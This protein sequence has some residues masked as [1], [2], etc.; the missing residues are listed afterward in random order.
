MENNRGKGQLS[1]LA[2]ASRL[3]LSPSGRSANCEPELAAA[4]ATILFGYY[5]R[6]EANDPEIFI[7]GATAML[8]SYPEIVVE[9]VCDPIRGLPAKSKFLPSI[10]EI[11]AACETEMVWFDT[12]ERRSRDRKHT[13][14]VLEPMLPPPAPMDRLRVRQAADELRAELKVANPQ[15]IDFRPPRSPAEA[16]AA[17]RHFDARVTE[18]ATEYAAKAPKIGPGLAKQPDPTPLGAESAT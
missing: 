2:D 17:R 9:R 10:A 6:N 13:A 18:L 4:R 15:A 8:S 7:T 1:R 14:K 3:V 16:E 11:R 5:P 12:V